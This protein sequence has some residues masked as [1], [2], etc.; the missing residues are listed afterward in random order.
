MEHNLDFVEILGANGEVQGVSAAIKPLG[1][2]DP[3]ELVGRQYQDIIHPEDRACA[4]KSFAR[5][6]HGTRPETVK[7][8]YRAKGGSWRS[9]LASTQS[10]LGDP[11]VHAVVVMTRD[12]TE[13][14]DVEAS[15]VLANSRVA[16]LTEQLTGAAERQRKYI[17]AELHDDVQQILVGLR[18]SMAASRRRPLTTFTNSPSF[19]G[20]P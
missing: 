6:L 16:D 4:E 12:V 15:L 14:C 18:M 3:R 13:Q 7:L 20:S 5:A 8:R 2:Y 10:F 17:A 9:I 19:C 11:A 1:G